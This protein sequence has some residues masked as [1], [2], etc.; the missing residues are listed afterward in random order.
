M[1]RAH[2]IITLFGSFRPQ[3]G[4]AGYRQAYA[5]GY[6]LAQAGFVICNGGYGGTME[7]AAKGAKEAGGRTIGIT[8]AGAPMTANPYLDREERRPTLLARLERLV[9]MADGYLVFKGG[10]GTLLEIAL[11]LEYTHKRFMSPKPMLFLGPFWRPAV[12]AAREEAQAMHMERLIQYARS[13]QAAVTTLTQLLR[14]TP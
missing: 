11:V 14:Q 1:K 12:T 8:F 5:T 4:S 10:T 9:T 2:R 13:P 6:A 7:A 3:P